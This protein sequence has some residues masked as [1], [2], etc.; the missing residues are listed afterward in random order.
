MGEW[1]FLMLGH[2]C[3]CGVCCC[4]R[5]FYRAVLSPSY[6]AALPCG[7][8][9]ED[10]VCPNKHDSW[11]RERS[12]PGWSMVH[13]FNPSTGLGRQRQNKTWKPKN[14]KSKTKPYMWTNNKQPTG[15]EF[16]C[17]AR[18]ERK[19]RHEGS[20]WIPLGSDRTSG[21]MAKRYCSNWLY[22]VLAGGHLV[23]GDTDLPNGLQRL[24]SPVLFQ[25]RIPKVLG[26]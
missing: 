23:P 21:W 6:G 15:L 10:R 19:V 7:C 22:F 11:E 18:W 13:P 9:L 25:N 24:V 5:F 26:V 20:E 4:L 8:S 1:A 16:L 17:A 3:Q 2:L 12:R 14:K